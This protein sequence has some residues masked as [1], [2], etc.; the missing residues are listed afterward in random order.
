MG[1]IGCMGEMRNNKK[2]WFE[3][4]KERDYFEDKVIDVRIILK[5]ILWK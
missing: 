2:F 1:H 4:L 5:W 3:S